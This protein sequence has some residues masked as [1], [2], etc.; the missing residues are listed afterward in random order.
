MRVRIHV[1]VLM[2]EDKLKFRIYVKDVEMAF[3][4]RPGDVLFVRAPGWAKVIDNADGGVAVETVSVDLA[5][6]DGVDAHVEIESLD[7]HRL[8]EECRDEFPD[9][10]DA[11]LEEYLSGFRELRRNY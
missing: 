7:A 4:P 2:S 9:G 6:E 10:Q 11:V 8:Y 1:T 3:V 5:H